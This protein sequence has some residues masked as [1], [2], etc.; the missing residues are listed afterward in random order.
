M[1]SFPI[2]P[3]NMEP[4]TVAWNTRKRLV[5]R[6]DMA[7]RLFRELGVRQILIQ[8]HPLHGE[9][10]PVDLQY[11]AGIDDGLVFLGYLA[12]DRSEIGF[13]RVVIGIQH[14]TRDDAGRGCVH[15]PLGDVRVGFRRLLLE[16]ADLFLQLLFAAVV[17]FADRL[18]RVE[19]PARLRDALHHPFGELRKL[20]ELLAVWTARLAAKAA[21][22]LRHVGLESDPSLLSVVGDINA[23]L[24]LFPHNVS[25]AVGG[26]LVD[27]PAIDSLAFL[28][29]DQHRPEGLPAR[30]ASGVGGENPVRAEFHPNTPP[31]AAHPRWGKPI[32]H[33][34]RLILDYGVRLW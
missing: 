11:I 20:G 19:H 22:A 23:G 8:Q 24:D 26:D 30:H 31:C 29:F 2:A 21:P 3:A 4:D 13:I 28:L 32:D 14:R 7:F 10:G 27:L 34:L 16:A 9:I 12:R 1:R 15:E 17:N 25:Y 18:G 6:L 33:K 5:Q